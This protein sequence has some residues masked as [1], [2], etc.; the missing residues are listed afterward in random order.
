[1]KGA[2]RSRDIERQKKENSGKGSSVSM[3]VMREEPG[4]RDI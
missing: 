4:E 2:L 3:G 1:M